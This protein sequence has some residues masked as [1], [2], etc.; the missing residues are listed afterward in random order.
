MKDYTKGRSPEMLEPFFP[1]EIFRHII[2][3]C[4]LL[5]IECIA[6][7]FFPLPFKL[8]EKPDR[9]SWFLLPVYKLSRLV[10]NEI[11][12]ILILVAG[13]LVF[14]S[15]PFLSSGK[16]HNLLVLKKVKGFNRYHDGHIPE[17]F[18]LWQSPI[19]F[20]IVVITLISLIL[21][22]FI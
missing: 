6:V 5:V 17:R 9:I 10:H 15:W 14:I 2:V 8:I 16:I 13:A 21:L 1:N 3:S 20:T 12:L 19:Q 7:N 18:N 11:L 4:F 22:C